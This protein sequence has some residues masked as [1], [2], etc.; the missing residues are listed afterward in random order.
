MV[1]ERDSLIIYLQKLKENKYKISNHYELDI[2]VPLMLKYIGDTDPILRDNLIYTTFNKWVLKLKYFT[3][4]ELLDILNTVVDKNHMFFHIG[5]RD[6]F[7]VFTRSFSVIIICLILRRHREKPF[8]S[9]D[10]YM[11]VKNSLIEYYRK[12]KDLRGYIE[13][14]GWAHS[15]AH[16]ADGFFEIVL[17]KECTV[18]I[19]SDILDSI[20]NKLLNGYYIFCHEEDERMVNV[21]NAIYAR[22][23][24]S[25]EKFEM[26]L[27]L[28]EKCLDNFNG[29]NKYLSKIN[30]KNFMRSLSFKTRD[31]R[32]DEEVANL[33]HNLAME[34]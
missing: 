16:G 30:V 34:I 17:S 8:L 2:Y 33:I 20:M 3:E 18:E 9:K 5:N 27:M 21:V 31:L 10:E 29:Y 28:L 11:M 32:Y 24:F 14:Y 1:N 26:W 23:F 7:T 25:I 12:E 15:A 4:N 22:K 13:N 19:C 6:D